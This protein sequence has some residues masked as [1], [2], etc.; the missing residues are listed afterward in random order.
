MSRASLASTSIDR[1]D[2][3]YAKPEHRM[4]PDF[5]RQHFKGVALKDEMNRR[6]AKRAERTNP[7]VA[8][9]NRA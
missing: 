7:D 8:T 4:R 1:T 2:A 5:A 3:Y 9:E 6:W